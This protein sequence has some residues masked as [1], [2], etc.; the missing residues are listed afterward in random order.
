[1]FKQLM[2][3]T[4][5]AASITAGGTA[6]NPVSSIG[7]QRLVLTTSSTPQAV[8]SSVNEK[9]NA[10]AKKLT[11]WSN[12]NYKHTTYK[13]YSKIRDMWSEKLKKKISASDLKNQYD[14]SVE[15]QVTIKTISYKIS[16]ITVKKDGTKT[17]NFIVTESYSDMMHMPAVKI[18]ENWT[19][20]CDSKYK[21]TSYEDIGSTD[22]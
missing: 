17:V 9:L 18:R 4:L 6:T 1:M 14:Q 15:E 20:T 7:N 8:S 12:F 13:Q 11:S 19:F 5:I 16:K 3:V 21:L 2:A 22:L 10:I